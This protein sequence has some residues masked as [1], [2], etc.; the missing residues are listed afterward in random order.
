MTE[1]PATADSQHQPPIQR[2]RDTFYETTSC[3]CRFGMVGRK[4]LP[5][6]K[7]V[8]LIAIHKKFT[9]ALDL[10]CQHDHQHEKAEDSNT[11]LSAQ[12]PPKLADT[13]CKAYLDIVA[14]E[15]FGAHHSWDPMEPRGAHYVDVNKEE[16]RWRPL[17]DEAAEILARK[18]QKDLF[19]D[20]SIGKLP[21]C[22]CPINQKPRGLD[23]DLRSAT[24]HPSYYKTTTP[25]SCSGT[26]FCSTRSLWYGLVIQKTLHQRNLRL[27]NQFLL[28]EMSWWS[29]CKRQWKINALYDK[30]MAQVSA[31]FKDLLYCKNRRSWRLVSSGFTEAWD[32]LALRT[33]S[34]HWCSTARWTLSASTWQGA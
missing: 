31:G 1:N 5:F 23:Q 16:P 13:I 14:E 28:K 6:L 8:R 24:E 2:L 20:P 30:I 26:S 11:S 21:M 3:M 9:D 12:Y 7:R 19:I 25:F 17:F 27:Y 32:I 34:T 18:V 4:G 15:D 22:R 33:S 10:Q 29:I